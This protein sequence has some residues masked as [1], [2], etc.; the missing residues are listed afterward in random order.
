LAVLFNSE[1]YHFMLYA[2]AI[3]ETLAKVLIAHTLLSAQMEVA[4]HGVY[5]DITLMESEKKCYAV[6][7]TAEPEHYFFDAIFVENATNP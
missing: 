6:G 3:A 5:R 2:E 4:V 7:T 1:V